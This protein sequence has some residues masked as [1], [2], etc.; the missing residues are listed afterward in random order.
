LIWW[1]FLF[2]CRSFLVSCGSICQSFLL[3]AEPLKLLSM[4]ICSSVFLTLFCTT[5]KVACLVLKILIHIEFIFA[6]GERNESSFSFLHTN[7]Q[8]SQQHLLKR[9]SFLHYVF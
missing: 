4:P 6:Q 8:F 3:V 2:F 7:S 5:F 1:P 9:Q